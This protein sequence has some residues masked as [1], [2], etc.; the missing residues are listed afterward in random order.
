MSFDGGVDVCSFKF[1]LTSLCLHILGTI[2]SID[3]KCITSLCPLIDMVG[4]GVGRWV[5]H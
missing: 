1:A 5:E 3:I 2:D 4:V